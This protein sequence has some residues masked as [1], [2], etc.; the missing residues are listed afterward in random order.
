MQSEPLDQTYSNPSSILPV[1]NPSSN[2]APARSSV[3]SI[4][5][6]KNTDQDMVDFINGLENT[7]GF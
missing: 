1:S 4:T 6:T 7:D 2:Q 3:T 5:A